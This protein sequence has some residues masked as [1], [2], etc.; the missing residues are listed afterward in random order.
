MLGVKQLKGLVEAIAGKQV[1]FGVVY[2]QLKL[3]TQFEG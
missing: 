3:L 1:I 2:R